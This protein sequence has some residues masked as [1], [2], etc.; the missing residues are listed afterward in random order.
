MYRVLCTEYCVPCTVYC[1]LCTEFFQWS[2]LYLLCFSCKVYVHWILYLWLWEPLDVRKWMFIWNTEYNRIEQVH[3][4]CV[5]SR[6]GDRSLFAKGP[7]SSSSSL[8]LLSS[9]WSSRPAFGD[10]REKIYLSYFT[11]V[12][13]LKSLSIL[14]NPR[15]N[16]KTSIKNVPF[17]NLW[18][19]IKSSKQD[20]K[21]C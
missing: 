8:I 2:M 14:W 13:I 9:F 10:G 15:Q 12:S 7:P 4:L 5:D 21:A 1:V 18:P 11:S 20:L 19:M 6:P 3:S 17:M 16:T